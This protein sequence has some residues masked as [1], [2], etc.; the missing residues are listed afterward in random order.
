MNN[1]LRVKF[2]SET[3]TLPTRA[4]ASDAG[5]DLYSSE[6]CTIAPGERRK[7]KTGIAVGLPPGCYGRVVS[8]SGLASRGI[9]VKAGAIDRGYTGEVLV[10]LKNDSNE[11]FVITVGSKIAQLICELC[12]SPNIH[13]VSELVSTNRGSRGFGSSGN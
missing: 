6:A 1:L 12:L 3:A 13:R 9:D 4:Y 11:D 8:R 2:L 5:Y 10:L 7:I